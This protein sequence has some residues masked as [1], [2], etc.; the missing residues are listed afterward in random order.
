MTIVNEAEVV[1][2]IN[3]SQPLQVGERFVES[4]AFAMEVD[5]ER[6]P[7]QRRSDKN[8]RTALEQPLGGCPIREDS[9]EKPVE[10]LQTNALVLRQGRIGGSRPPR[11][12]LDGIVDTSCSGVRPRFRH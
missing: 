10:V 4:M 12:L 11:N 1:T 2:E 3:G 9:T 7:G 6:A 5:V 8:A